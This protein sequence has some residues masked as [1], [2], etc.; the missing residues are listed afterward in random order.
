MTQTP[1]TGDAAKLLAAITHQPIAGT[2][3]DV[4]PPTLEVPA[5]IPERLLLVRKSAGVESTPSPSVD[6]IARVTA[7]VEWAASNI[8]SAEVREEAHD[9]RARSEAAFEKGVFQCVHRE[10]SALR[11]ALELADA[12]ASGDEPSLRMKAALDAA[13]A[14]QARLR[15]A[16][17]AWRDKARN[18]ATDDLYRCGSVAD[19]IDEILRG[20]PPDAPA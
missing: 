16:L 3:V 7:S 5:W 14:E 10:L 8:R 1:L 15:R 12:Y 6:A 19:R 9:A 13:L 2:A 20:A 11:D 17:E 4:A 18:H